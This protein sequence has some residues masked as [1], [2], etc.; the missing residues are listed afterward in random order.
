M[1]VKDTEPTGCK[2][3]FQDGTSATSQKALTKKW[4]EM[5]QRIEGNRHVQL[6]PRH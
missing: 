1:P 3:V 2:S 6:P 5:I 4:I